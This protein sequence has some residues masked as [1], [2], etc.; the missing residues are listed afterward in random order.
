MVTTHS[1]A[2]HAE[3]RVSP[4]FFLVGLWFVWS[5]PFGTDEASVFSSLSNYPDALQASCMVLLVA[6]GVSA[7]LVAAL[8][9]FVAPF[10]TRT[11]FLWPFDAWCRAGAWC[12]RR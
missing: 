6:F 2:Q 12:M 4:R 10:H 9:R 3:D 1:E 8:S 11:Q 5:P 7:A